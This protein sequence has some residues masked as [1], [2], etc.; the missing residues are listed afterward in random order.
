[1]CLS[2]LDIYSRPMARQRRHLILYVSVMDVSHQP[3]W[4]ISGILPFIC[5]YLP[6]IC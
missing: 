1:M 2:G 4:A 3:K 5:Y 6:W